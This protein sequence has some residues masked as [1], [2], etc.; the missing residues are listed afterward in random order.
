MSYSEIPRVTSLNNLNKGETGTI[1]QIRGKPEEHRNL[2]GM[3]LAMGR[4]ISVNGTEAT[5]QGLALT[6]KSGDKVAKLENNIAQNI[7]VRVSK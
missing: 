7:K 1:I 5:P 2:Y 4:V 6:V 3:G